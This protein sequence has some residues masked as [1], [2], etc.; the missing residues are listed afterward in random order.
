MDNALATISSGVVVAALGGI[1]VI[2]YRHP[3]AYLRLM[4]CLWLILAALAI[5][6][7]GYM[8]GTSYAALEA[9]KT[10]FRQDSNLA[11]A[12]EMYKAAES[13]ALPGWC[14]FVLGASFAYLWF[15]SSF[16]FWLLDKDPS[17]NKAS[18]DS[19]E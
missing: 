19:N 16:P 12:D 15:L 3:R 10:S 7:I 18:N 17:K 14:A 11:K 9:S 13:H 8:M 2:A 6:G 4:I 1:T 5:G